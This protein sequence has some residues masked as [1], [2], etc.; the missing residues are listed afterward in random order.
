MLWEC[1]EKCDINSSV[2]FSLRLKI[3]VH[4]GTLELHNIFFFHTAHLSTV[5]LQELSVMALLFLKTI[6]PQILFA[7]CCANSTLRVKII[8]VWAL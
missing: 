5:I 8:W 1:S 6:R 2:I 4:S 7:H 3:P